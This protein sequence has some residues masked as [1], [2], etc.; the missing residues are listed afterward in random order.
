MTPVI[1]G[2]P[3]RDTAVIHAWSAS[4]LHI[5]PGDYLKV[6]DL[7]LS[8]SLPTDRIKTL[9]LSTASLVLQLQNLGTI[10]FN[11]RG[12]NAESMDFYYYGWGMR[13][14]P[15]P[16]IISLGTTINF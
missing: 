14:I 2:K 7:T 12:Y 5:F 10:S 15:S 11:R 1:T 4:D 9:G 3:L 13:G 8:Y 6:Q 16:L